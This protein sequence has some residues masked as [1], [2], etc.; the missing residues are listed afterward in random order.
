MNKIAT[1]LNQSKCPFIGKE[2][3]QRLS[4]AILD[5]VKECVPKEYSVNPYKLNDIRKQGYNQCRTEVLERIER[6]G[7]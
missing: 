5:A 7:E 6:L 1:I 2:A 4:K 3:A